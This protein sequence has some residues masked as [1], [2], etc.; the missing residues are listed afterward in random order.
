MVITFTTIVTFVCQILLQLQ[1]YYLKKY[2]S[3]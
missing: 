1:L 3:N 2:T